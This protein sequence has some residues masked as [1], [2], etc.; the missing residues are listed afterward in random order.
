MG[1]GDDEEE[2]EEVIELDA[3]TSLLAN[4]NNNN[5]MSESE[6][7]FE[8]YGNKQE[9]EEIEVLGEADL[10]NEK[11]MVEVDRG[12]KLTKRDIPLSNWREDR[13]KKLIL[14]HIV[15]QAMMISE[16]FNHIGSTT[17]ST[18]EPPNS[19]VVLISIIHEC[20]EI[21]HQ[22]VLKKHKKSKSQQEQRGAIVMMDAKS[23][24]KLERMLVLALERKLF[25]SESPLLGLVPT[26]DESKQENR[27]GIIESK[28]LSLDLVTWIL[29]VAVKSLEFYQTESIV[30]CREKVQSIMM[31]FERLDKIK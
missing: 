29:A 31:A 24:A 9:T 26:A 27:I 5:N 20:G 3:E 18:T 2:E 7:E 23:F 8:I 16:I 22:F 28:R 13:E 10:A 17:T 25:I 12:Y 4:D 14:N 21:I 1:D 19:K 15:V 6:L 30:E 11:P